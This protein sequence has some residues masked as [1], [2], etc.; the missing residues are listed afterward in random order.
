MSLSLAKAVAMLQLDLP[1]NIV[2]HLSQY[3]DLLEKWNRTY[4]LT[5]IREREKMIS[6]HVQDAL[7][8]LPTLD[9][10]HKAQLSILDIGTGAGIPGLILALAR[11]DWRLTLLDSNSKKTRFLVQAVAQLGLKNVTVEHQRIEQ[12]QAG[13]NHF[14]I[15]ISRAYSS[16]RQFYQDAQ[17]HCASNGLMIAMKG[18]IPEEELQHLSVAQDE[19]SIEA[20]NIPGLDAERH[21]ISLSPA[22]MRSR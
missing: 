1:E 19:L 8:V 9:K 7:V 18:K 3:L 22:S 20:L 10:R 6:H 11:S 21:L 4:N 13:K 14:D 17:P 2:Q 12:W 15:V 5:A 16:L